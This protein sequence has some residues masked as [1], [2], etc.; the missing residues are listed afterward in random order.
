MQKTNNSPN[1]GNERK[2]SSNLPVWTWVVLIVLA[3]VFMVS[4]LFA[5]F[6]SFLVV[7]IIWVILIIFLK[8]GALSLMMTVV[9]VIVVSLVLVF[10]LMV[11][12][13][14]NENGNSVK[15]TESLPNLEMTV[16]KHPKTINCDDE[17]STIEVTAKNVGEKDLTF[18]EVGD[19]KYDFKICDGN[20]E[21]GKSSCFTLAGGY[22]N[23]N[24]FGVIGVGET[25]NI[26]FT[27]PAK[28][29]NA[30]TSFSKSTVNGEYEYYIDFSQIKNPKLQPTLSKS[31]MFTVKTNIMNPTNEYIKANCRKK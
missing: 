30:I 21:E 16:V 2:K 9:S 6:W 20:T 8:K 24:D 19:G 27:T 15:N 3:G 18:A 26:V 7:S 10:Y 4:A 1:K 12:T 17:M 14:G 11:F 25:K 23:M 5:G 31:D 28:Y 22:L 13:T 29:D